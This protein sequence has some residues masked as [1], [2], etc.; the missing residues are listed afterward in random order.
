MRLRLQMIL[1]VVLTTITS[2]GAYGQAMYSFDTTE[3]FFAP[4]AYWSAWQ[5]TL[6][7]HHLEREAIHRCLGDEETCSRRLKGLR[8][9]LLKGAGLE[10]EQQ[11][12]L[13][14]RYINKHHYKD[15]RVSSRST[16]G[17]QWETLTE[18]LHGGGDCED[19]AVAKYFLLREFGIDAE[20]MRIVIGKESQRATHHAMLA[21][22][23]DED[24]WLLENDNTIHRNGYQDINRF[25]YAINEQGIWDHERRDKQ[26]K[27]K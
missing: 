16:A 18:F 20:N 3:D 19:F 25:V 1:A 22:R 11:I 2:T 13:V 4:A 7:R 27:R 10:R 24:V 23:F 26:Q 6:D 8:H 15:D 12:R 14:N 5:D 9:I 21:I 17:N